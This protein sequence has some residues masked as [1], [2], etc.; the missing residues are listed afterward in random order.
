M[1]K[2]NKYKQAFPNSAHSHRHRQSDVVASRTH[3]NA[4]RF[5]KNTRTVNYSALHMPLTHKLS[6]TPA[7]NTQRNA[8]MYQNYI[9]ILK[10]IQTQSQ[11]HC[12]C[13]PR[14]NLQHSTHT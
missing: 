2:Y 10:S 14:R 6:T 12:A 3:G 11:Q 9:Y 1:E 8:K 4:K 5:G 13:A 7:Q